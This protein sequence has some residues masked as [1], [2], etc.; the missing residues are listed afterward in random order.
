M[1]AMLGALALIE[2]R[3]PSEI[4]RDPSLHRCTPPP[5]RRGT[6]QIGRAAEPA[7]RGSSVLTQKLCPRV[8]RPRGFSLV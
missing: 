7:T 6:E 4:D 3:M 5:W 8:C 1:S 2:M